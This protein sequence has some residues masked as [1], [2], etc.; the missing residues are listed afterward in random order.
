MCPHWRVVVW[1]STACPPNYLNQTGKL[2]VSKG[3][4][5]QFCSPG[6]LKVLFNQTLDCV[7]K[8]T[9]YNHSLTFKFISGATVWQLN[10]TANAA[11]ANISAGFSGVHATPGVHFR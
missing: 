4:V 6:C 11:C 1:Q 9:K 5:Q 2:Y 3:Q 8:V 10:N 7:N